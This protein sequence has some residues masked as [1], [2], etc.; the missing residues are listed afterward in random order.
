[1]SGGMDGCVGT[2]P[3]SET[4]AGWDYCIH[5]PNHR[6]P[7][8]KEGKKPGH[9]IGVCATDCDSD[10]GCEGNL[11]CMGRPVGKK[12]K[13]SERNVARICDDEDK[14]LEGKRGH[15]DVCVSPNHPHYT[16]DEETTHKYGN[17]DLYRQIN[18]T[19]DDCD[20]AMPAVQC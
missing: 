5:P 3:S 15:W 2:P 6:F 12:H 18:D 9:G 19:P 11:L 17:P 1:M 8:I 20:G 16:T 7:L 13:N 14:Y 10:K 4:N